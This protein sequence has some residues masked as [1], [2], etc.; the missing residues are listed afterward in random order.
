MTAEI[1]RPDKA[2]IV[3][4]VYRGKREESVHYGSIAVV[5]NEGKLTHYLGDPEFFTFARSSPKPF[6]LLPTVTS[7]ASDKFGFTPKQLAI[8]CGSHSGSDE[9][10]EVV[11]S[12]LKAA[13][14][15]PEHLKCG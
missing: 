8:M 11:L 7:G 4:R 12:N 13:G 2:E 15:G 9:H 6:Q 3:A 14:N 10:R 5:N 1:E